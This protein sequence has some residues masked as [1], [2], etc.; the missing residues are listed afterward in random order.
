MN[1][2]ILAAGKGTRMKS[3]LPKV[4]HPLA[5]K[6]MLAHVIDTAMQIDDAK[7]YC[8]VGH[9]SELVVEYF[10]NDERYSNIEWVIQSEQ[11]GTGHAVK[12]AVEKID[13]DNASVVLYGDVPLISFD[14]I[15]EVLSIANNGNLAVITSVLEDA[16]ALGR[17]VRNE[18]NEFIAIRE[19]KDATDAER[20]I[21]EINSGIMAIPG[22]KL[23]NWLSR[24]DNNNAQSE[25]YLTDVVELSIEDGAQVKSVDVINVN[26]I[27]GVN[28]LFDLMNLE[29]AY[30]VENANA[31]L[32]NG[33][34][35]A[36]NHRFDI[37][38][39]LSHGKDCRVDINCIIEGDCQFGDRVKI[40]SN[41]KIINSSIGD[42]TVILDNTI[43]E[44]SVVG[45]QCNVGPFA[46]IRPQTHLHDNVKIGNF[47]ET[48]K[49]KI[50]NNS[51]VNHL[52][53][54]GDSDVGK[55]V[56]I[57]AGVITCN[58]DGANKHKTIIG[59]NVFVGSDCQLIAPVEIGSGATIGAGTT[60]YK[61]AESDALTLN[62]R[63][64]KS[65]K[66]WSRP[67]KK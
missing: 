18:N 16:G 53:Y 20:A 42:D 35:I 44:N 45:I 12:Q 24:I 67:V 55:D 17:I 65:Y 30:Q 62:G 6:P 10:S 64:L 54:V 59:D 61:N 52:S 32:N 50:D 13:N 46:R 58:Y 36:D 48:K 63:S 49:A 38:G 25:Y 28:S 11:N 7:I 29:R 40:G 26:E 8:V 43:I 1:I 5:G 19:Y 37:R 22:N 31:L 14:K 21:K 3:D 41:V 51:K 15:N 56:N 47:V 60:L 4:L 2:I 9:K 23:K 39:S 33:C 57:G 34:F 27:A 66:S